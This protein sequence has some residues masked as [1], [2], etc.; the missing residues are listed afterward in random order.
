MGKVLIIRKYVLRI[1]SNKEIRIGNQEMRLQ[2]A[3]LETLFVL[4]HSTSYYYFI[5]KYFLFL[6]YEMSW[7]NRYEKMNYHLQHRWYR[8]NFRQ[9]I[10][11]RTQIPGE[12]K[13]LID[14]AGRCFMC[15]SSSPTKPFIQQLKQSAHRRH[16]NF[17]ERTQ[18]ILLQHDAYRAYRA[19]PQE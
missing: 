6:S 15:V 13:C 18:R 12:R 10:K 16:E 8:G 17:S 7:I 9:M 11:A 4:L 1:I 3:E 19:Y 2:T 14:A 5:V